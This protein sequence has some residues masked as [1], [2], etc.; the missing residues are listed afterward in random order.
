MSWEQEPSEGDWDRLVA[1]LRAAESVLL[2]AHV[3]PDADALGSALAAG[4]AMRQLGIPAVVSFDESPFRVPRSLAWLP[5]SEILVPVELTPTR[6]DVAVSFDASAIERLGRLGAVCRGAQLFAAVDHHRSYTG[7]A[8]ISL[9]DVTAPAAAVLALELVDR[10]GA[11]L[12][13]DIATCIYAGVTTDT[14]SFQFAGTTADTHRLVARLHDAGIEH[15][16][17]ARAVFADRPFAS[18]QLLGRALD[19][20][21][22]DTSALGGLGLV[23]TWVS[24]ADRRELGLHLDAAESIIDTLR[25][26][27]QAHVAVVLKEGDDHVWRVST[28]SK[29][30]I[31]VSAVCGD[32]GGGGHRSAAGYSEEG[33]REQVLA[34][35]RDGLETQAKSIS[36]P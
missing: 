35:L 33:P 24:L 3:N 1:R 13:K 10:L 18:L 17:I 8:Q 16:L 2:V 20:A 23:S 15:D 31:D 30:V 34:R 12:T 32:L 7:F 22:L 36:S 19:H 9:V 4:L 26:T 28:R 21:Q 11:V 27:S 29:G 6:L 14:G 25:E 5:G